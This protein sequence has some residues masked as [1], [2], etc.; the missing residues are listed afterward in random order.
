M[1]NDDEYS[2]PDP[3]DP[4]VPEGLPE[5]VPPLPVP[6][7]RA[8]NLP[9]QTAFDWLRSG[10][11]DF[12]ADPAPSLAYACSAVGN[13]RVRNVATLGGNLA[14]ADY[15]SD[16]PATLASLGARCHVTGPGGVIAKD[17]GLHLIDANIAM[18]NLVD[19]VGQQAKA[20]AAN[21]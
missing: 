12:R 21:K 16:P 13:P 10:W 20:Y 2:R 17:W 18:G 11:R 6:N 3:I 1:L 8:R 14:E 7:E 4:T 19:V 15:A 9:W 5:V